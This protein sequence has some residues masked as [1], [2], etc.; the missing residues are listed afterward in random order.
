MK[1]LLIIAVIAITGS[2][3]ELEVDFYDRI[4]FD[5]YPENAV[6]A[7]L[8]T[9]PVY[10]PLTEFLDWGGWWFCQEITGDALVIPTRLT[11]WDD[12]G[13]WR[14]L[15]QHTWTNTTEAVEAMWSRY[16]RGVVEANNLIESLE[17]GAEIPATATALAK[18]RILRAFY[19]YLLIDNY[20]D[21]P[22]VTSFS[23]APARP[24]KE[25]RAVIFNNIVEEVEES[26]PFLDESV[27]KTSVTKG[28]AFTLLAKLYLNHA[29]Y[30]GSV[31]T[32]YWAAAEAAADSVIALNTYSLET[33]PLAP[34]VTTNENSPENIFT[35]PFDEDS[36]QG[37]NLHMRTLHYQSNLTF[38]M[39]IGPWNGLA[40]LESHYNSYENNDLRKAGFLVG[41]Q[42]TSTGQSITDIVA[43]APL[44]FNPVIPALL[45]DGSFN[46]IQIRMSGARIAKFEIKLGAKENLSNDFP[47]FRY[48]DVLLMK[49]EARLRQGL[50]GDTWVNLIR[51]RANVAPYTNITL[52]QLLE[53]RGREMFFE[54]HRRQDLI[55]F[56]KF[57]NPWWEKPESLAVRNIFPIPQREIDTNPNLE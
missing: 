23:D 18:M 30:T 34:F 57:N 36:K 32:A 26:I 44:S 52:D 3:T 39:P 37:F 17:P 55:R 47:L 11:D 10:R 12:G 24:N 40:A 46:P 49:S 6:Q 20:G 56:G 50:S 2:C 9:E 27:S 42:Y 53:E 45:M 8:L 35:I 31:N 54:G 28:M 13:K 51:E 21:V 22:Y 43:G 14:V 1:K 19:Y 15:H 16:Y 4:P 41:R 25:S 38:N 29:V 33:S 5:R 7:A 48:A